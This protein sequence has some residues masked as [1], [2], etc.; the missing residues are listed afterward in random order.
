RAQ[1]E[2]EHQTLP[3]SPVVMAPDQDGAE[4]ANTKEENE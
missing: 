4:V 2:F 1:R 3:Q